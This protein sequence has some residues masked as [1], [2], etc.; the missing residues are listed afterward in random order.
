MVHKFTSVNL[1]KR[2]PAFD[3]SNLSVI[4]LV[5]KISSTKMRRIFLNNSLLK[6]CRLFTL[7]LQ[8]DKPGV[9]TPDADRVF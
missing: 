7:S 2:L 6:T 4:Y 3:G 8:V 5:G 1:L 9:R